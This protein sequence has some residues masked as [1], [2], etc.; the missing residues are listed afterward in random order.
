MEGKEREVEEKANGRS[1]ED[2]EKKR[3]KEEEKIRPKG[4]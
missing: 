3:G 4:R 1:S 2:K